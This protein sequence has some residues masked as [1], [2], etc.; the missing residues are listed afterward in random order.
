MVI[1]IYN[2]LTRQKEPFVPHEESNVKFY[3]CGPTVYD[4]THIG[5]G[6]SYLVFDMVRRYLEY[7]DYTVKHVQNFTDVEDKIINRSKETGEA[8]DSITTRYIDEFLADM[9]ALNVKRAD[10]Y[11]LASQE[12]AGIVEMIQGLIAKGY[13][14]ESQGDVYFRVQRDEDYGKLS[15]RKLDEQ[16][17]GTRVSDE[18][19]ERKEHAQD[20]AL[21]K[22]AK[23]DEPSWESPWGNGRPGWHIECSEMSLRYLGEQIDIHGGGHDLIFPHHENE[24]AQSESFTGKVPFVKY[25]MHNGLLQVTGEKM[26]KSLKNFFRIH[27]FLEKHSA[28]AL[29][30]FVLSSHYRRPVSYTEESFAAAERAM[31]RF[32]AALQPPRADASEADSALR[33]LA[34]ET[35]AKFH[36]AMDDDF[37]TALALG[38]LFE[39]ARALNGARDRGVAVADFVPAQQTLAGAAWG[40]R[41]PPGRGRRGHRHER[42]TLHRAAHRAAQRATQGKAVGARRQRARPHGSARRHPGGHAAGHGVEGGVGESRHAR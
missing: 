9:A 23:P 8:W 10:V 17:A 5:H 14:Y 42:R 12:I 33:T 26:S 31:E 40:A 37:N 18:E 7:R 27:D 11:P 41:L 16:Q 25:W 36:A 38:A 3:V 13:A 28:D 32:L 24:I 19:R 29:R 1:Q 21:W 20:F 22:A 4:S 35:E 2:T 34:G 6:M 30:L 15:N 39:L